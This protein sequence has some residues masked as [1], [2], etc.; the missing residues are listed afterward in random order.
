[1]YFFAEIERM[2]GIQGLMKSNLEQHR[3]IEDS[4][5]LLRKYAEGTG[6]EEF[7]GCTLRAMIE[8]LRTGLQEHLEGEIGTI[9]DLWDKIDS[10]ALEKIDENWKEVA[11]RNSDIFK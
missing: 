6:K 11:E 10:A 3:R 1:L 2:T 5:D 7:R 8:E 9:V 4:L